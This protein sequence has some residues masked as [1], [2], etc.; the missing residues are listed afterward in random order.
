MEKEVMRRVRTIIVLLH[1]NTLRL[2]RRLGFG[3]APQGWS[4]IPMLAQRGQTLLFCSC[5]FCK[6]LE[7]VDAT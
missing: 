4:A 1:S 6:V 2:R 3:H 5:L 7:T